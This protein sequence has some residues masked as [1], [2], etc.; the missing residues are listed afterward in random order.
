MACRTSISHCCRTTSTSTIR[1][2]LTW[3]ALTLF[4]FTVSRAW[5]LFTRTFLCNRLLR[6]R[7]YWFWLFW[8]WLLFFMLRCNSVAAGFYVFFAIFMFRF[9][10]LSINWFGSGLTLKSLL[11]SSFSFSCRLFLSSHSFVLTSR[12]IRYIESFILRMWHSR[13]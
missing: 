1:I 12:F 13:L 5:C 4:S 3:H 9:V 10:S 8:D 6:F 11:F 2:V 7:H